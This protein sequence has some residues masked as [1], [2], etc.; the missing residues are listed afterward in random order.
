MDSNQVMLSVTRRR[1]QSYE[2]NKLEEW[3]KSQVFKMIIFMVSSSITGT[4][5][6]LLLLN[7]VRQ[8]SPKTDWLKAIIIF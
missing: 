1:P 5:G 4:E 8:M 6:C 2:A 7:E 3:L